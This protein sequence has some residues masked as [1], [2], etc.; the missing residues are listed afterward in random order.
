M[1]IFLS[2]IIIT[3]LTILTCPTVYGHPLSLQK[4]KQGKTKE[5][6]ERRR[7]KMELKKARRENQRERRERRQRGNF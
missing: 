1:K 3:L 6:L 7:E 2:V 5:S 4:K